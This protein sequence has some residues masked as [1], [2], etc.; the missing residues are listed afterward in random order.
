LLAA[1]LLIAGAINFSNLSI[2]ASV[3]RAKEVGVRKVLGSGRKQLLWQ[4]MGEA[5]MQCFISLCVALLAVNFLLSYFNKL[6]SI[7]LSLFQTGNALSI[8]AQIVLCLLIVIVLSGLYPAIFLIRY[9]ITRVLKGDYSTGTKGI[10]IRN[11]LI[12]FQFTVSAFFIIG[13][14]IISRQMHYMQTRDKGF[15]GEQVIRV[16]ATQKT[17]EADFETA[18]NTLLAIPGVQYVSKTTTVPG[19]AISDTSTIAYKLNGKECRMGSVKVST[20]Y[21]KTLSIPLVQGRLFDS[22]YADQNT[23]SAII[24]QAAAEKLHLQNPVGAT[25]TFPHCDTVPV[26]IIGVVKNFNVSGFENAVKP[27]VFTVGNKACIFQSGGAI[28]VKL[29]SNNIQQS[30]AAIEKTWKNIEPDFP[31]RYSFLDENFQKLFAQ[32]LRLQQIINFFGFT[33][34]FIS[35][36]GLFALT[37]FLMNRRI[38]E[39]SIR[40]ILGAGIS[41]L[42]LLLGK[43]FIRLVLIAVC[44][45]TP[46]GWWAA[47]VWLQSFAYRITLSWWMFAIATM[48]VVIVAICVI[49]IQAVK[50]AIAN[51]VKSLRTE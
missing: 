32:Y 33:A 43:D 50:A 9:N 49:G 28:L 44:I 23:R 51:P 19:D 24:N 4:F 18:R 34:I 8:A 38:K 2:A 31:I 27:V 40:K 37:A 1:L 35:I 12:V 46:L 17:R 7:H 48:I 10:S 25:I 16:Q 21:F 47:Q 13:T 20:E 29:N 45:A 41:D 15:S 5:M 26:N 39:I 11:A 30:V 14:L 36:M 6:F 42:S 3:K 22:R